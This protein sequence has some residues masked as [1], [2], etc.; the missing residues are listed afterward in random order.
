MRTK[1]WHI[2][3]IVHFAG[4][5]CILVFT[6][7][8]MG[9]LSLQQRIVGVTNET[10]GV[11]VPKLL[12][13]IRAVR[14]LEMLSH[15]GSLAAKAA[16]PAVRRDAAFFA[17]YAAANPGNL[18]DEPTR[19]LV[20]EAYHRIQSIASRELDPGD[21]PEMESRLTARAD[22]L[23]VE[24]GHLV[25]Q[26]ATGIYDDS[27]TVRNLAIALAVLFA[28]SMGMMLVL[29]RFLSLKV[30]NTAQLFSEASHDFR[31]RLHGMQLLI[32]TAKR[33]PLPEGPAI[34]SRLEAITGDLQ[35]YLDNFLEIARLEAVV[36]KPVCHQ[37]ALQDVFQRLELQ[38]QETALHNQ[39]DIKFRHTRLA[40]FSD[41]KMLMRILENLIANALKFARSKVLV[42]VRQRAGR[43]EVWVVDNGPGM[44]EFKRQ[45]LGAA[46]VQG[47]DDPAGSA[48]RGFGLGLSIVIRLADL[49]DAPV[50]ILS[51]TGRGAMVRVGFAAPPPE[52]AP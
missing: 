31:Q 26:R 2:R 21:W 14:N 1:N 42:A 6:V 13:Q 24:T 10:R 37:I 35:R 17:A 15:Y 38:F 41:E 16:D 27:L 3:W 43:V 25:V 47:R 36:A 45:G 7:L 44:P 50:S 51:R 34:L 12:E 20:A 48:D 29:G 52:L 22:A 5:L 39:V 28:V 23:A 18:D 30:R 9:I 49:L 40:C 32:N 46:F 11:L 8:S 4:V 19:R 33:S